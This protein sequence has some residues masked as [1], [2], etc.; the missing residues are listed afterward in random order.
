MGA[1]GL[2]RARSQFDWK[3]VYGQYRALWQELEARRRRAGGDADEQRRLARAPRASAQHPDPFW[4]FSHYPTVLLRPASRISLAPGAT[5]AELDRLR[6]DALF[7]AVPVGEAVLTA[8]WRAIVGGVTTVQ[9][10]AGACN[11][12]VAVAQRGVGVLAKMGLVQ[13][14]PD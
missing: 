5:E 8:L 12:H 1:S 3:V 13:V 6:R 4:L 10:A 7:G 9:G 2:G 14:L 11:V